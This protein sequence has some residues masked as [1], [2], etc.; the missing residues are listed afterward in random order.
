MPFL[1][2]AL[3]TDQKKA[4]GPTAADSSST[5]LRSQDKKRL[6]L[7]PQ[8]FPAS[9]QREDARVSGPDGLVPLLPPGG[10]AGLHRPVP[11]AGS[12]RGGGRSRLVI[13]TVGT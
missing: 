12:R 6:I 2:S 9:D 13:V 11:N 3:Q 1:L 5:L 10:L 4:A 7:S 8:R